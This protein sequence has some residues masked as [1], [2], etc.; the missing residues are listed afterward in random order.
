MKK[1]S[2]A[3]DVLKD[4]GAVD[5]L[6][7]D[8]KVKKDMVKQGSR[9]DVDTKMSSDF[10][11]DFEKIFS[12]DLGDIELRNSILLSAL[13]KQR[14]EILQIALK[15]KISKSDVLEYILNDFFIK[16]GND[17]KEAYHR[18]EKNLNNLF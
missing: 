10:S 4:F 5:N 18:K 9:F 15:Q 7:E 16:H 1:K 11:Y 12:K 6:D 14:I 3:E 2:N 17:V 8:V 13:N